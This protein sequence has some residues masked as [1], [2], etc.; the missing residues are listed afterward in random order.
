M[1]AKY[2]SSKFRKIKNLGTA[3]GVILVIENSDLGNSS[4]GV[5]G[6]QKH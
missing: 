6:C 4:T 2:F 5:T 3:Q 1:Y